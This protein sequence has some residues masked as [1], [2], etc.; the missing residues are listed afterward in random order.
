MIF[1]GD[2]SPLIPLLIVTFIV[3]LDRNKFHRHGKYFFTRI[4]AVAVAAS[5]NPLF[6]MIPAT[7]R[8]FV[9][10]LMMPSVS[11]T[12]TVIFASGKSP[13]PKWQNADWVKSNVHNSSD[14]S[15]IFCHHPYIR[16]EMTLPAWA[17]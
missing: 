12:N 13:F 7:F 17:G 6:L 2:Y 9:R 3:F 4:M 8:L 14:G 1:I 16:F 11:G 10:S 5:I 15:A